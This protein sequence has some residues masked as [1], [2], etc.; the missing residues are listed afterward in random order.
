VLNYTTL[1]V[2]RGLVVHTSVTIGYD[3]P[4]R[5][6]HELLIAAALKTDAVLKEPRPFVLQT[7]LND[8]S[9]AYEINAHVSDP[10]NL[11]GIYSALH[12]NIQECF[13]EAGVEIMSPNYLALRDGNRQTTP[14][15]HLPPDYEPPS[16]RVRNQV[17]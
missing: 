3:A 15:Q 10:S 2:A 8:F 1:A 14:R 16:I 5:Q 12:T 6:V 9:V 17:E 7:A 13:N 4:W 11:P